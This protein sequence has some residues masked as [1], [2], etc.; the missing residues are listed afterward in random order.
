MGYMKFPPFFYPY[1]S[2][3]HDTM[4]RGRTFFD[5]ASVLPFLF[6]YLAFCSIISDRRG[7]FEEQYFLSKGNNVNLFDILKA[8]P[9][10][11]DFCPWK[12]VRH[13]IIVARGKG[14][15]ATRL[16]VES[17]SEI[18]LIAQYIATKAERP[19]NQRRYL[20]VVK[21]LPYRTK[22]IRQNQ[23]MRLRYTHYSSQSA[24]RI[25]PRTHVILPL[26]KRPPKI[27]TLCRNL[28]VCR[29]QNIFNSF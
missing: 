24:A 2:H 20:A 14:Y 16:R 23:R 25:G 12:H 9:S 13:V 15:F 19:W 4:S 18:F 22:T 29:R 1:I 26:H 8:G 3:S 17:F 21:E 28:S 7:H 27:T 6:L 5:S 11:I 10:C